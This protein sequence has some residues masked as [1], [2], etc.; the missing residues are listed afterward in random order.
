MRGKKVIQVRHAITGTLISQWNAQCHH[1]SYWFHQL[2]S[3]ISNNIPYLAHS[4]PG[5]RYVHVY[6]ISRG[7]L[8]THYTQAGS[9]CNSAICLLIPDHLLM[10]T[11]YKTVEQ[12]QLKGDH[13]QF[14]YC[15]QRCRDTNCRSDGDICYSSLHDKIYTAISGSIV[16][17]SR[18][19]RQAWYRRDVGGQ[20]FGSTLSVCC[21][22][23]GRVYLADLST[24]RLLVLD[25]RTGEVLHVQE[26]MP[27]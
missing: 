1:D 22:T 26:G 3:W 15:V 21:D 19:G 17:T 23:A 11:W 16:C 9:F 12:L 8:I 4:C 7:Q 6:D 5:C 20:Q 10:V 13:L 2:A 14:F 25:G 24:K 18:S 27:P